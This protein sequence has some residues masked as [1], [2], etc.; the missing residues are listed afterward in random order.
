MCVC[1]HTY[2]SASMSWTHT[3]VCVWTR[4]CLHQCFMLPF[5]ALGRLTLIEEE[6]EAEDD[7]KIVDLDTLTLVSHSY[8]YIHRPLQTHLPH[9]YCVP[10]A[11]F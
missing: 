7:L 9:V 6:D 8:L 10:H 2:V 1:V 5:L 4:V 3:S 11:K